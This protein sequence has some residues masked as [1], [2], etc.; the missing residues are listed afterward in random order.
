MED[1]PYFYT[2]LGWM[3]SS[4]LDKIYETTVVLSDKVISQEYHMYGLFK[5]ERMAIIIKILIWSKNDF[6][7]TTLKG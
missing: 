7:P 4:L 3:G 5:A 1:F 6:Y 2:E